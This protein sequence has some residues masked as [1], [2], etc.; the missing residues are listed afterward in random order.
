MNVL[1]EH[2]NPW[3]LSDKSVQD[4][5]EEM[6]RSDKPGLLITCPPCGPFSAWQRMNYR[7]MRPEDIKKRLDEGIKHVAFA[8]KLCKIQADAGRKFVFEHPASASSWK[9]ALMQVLL[10]RSDVHKV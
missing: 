9:F 6:V 4:R 8:L 2:G 10:E 7:I 1:D 5:A 3:D